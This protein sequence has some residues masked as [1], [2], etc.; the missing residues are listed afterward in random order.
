MIRQATEMLWKG[1]ITKSGTCDKIPSVCR[2]GK[3]L[4]E[5]VISILWT[6]KKK[7]N[8]T[9]TQDIRELSMKVRRV[10][11]GR[12]PQAAVSTAMKMTWTMAMTTTVRPRRP[13]LVREAEECLNLMKMTKYYPT[14]PIK[15]EGLKWSI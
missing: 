3:I 4:G 1:S 8:L 9:W 15:R 10:A 7:N 14:S 13:N 5:A 12:T 11:V 2:S 6:S